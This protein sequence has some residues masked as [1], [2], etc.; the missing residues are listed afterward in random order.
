MLLRLDKAM[1][2][3]WK[4]ILWVA[5]VFQLGAAFGSNICQLIRCRP[6]HAMWDIVPNAKCWDPI[7]SWI[8]GYVFA[9]K[10]TI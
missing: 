2:T 8:Y 10:R 3:S 7:E 4:V 6:L 5:I 1:F 9:G